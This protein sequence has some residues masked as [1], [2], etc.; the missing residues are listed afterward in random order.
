ME[1]P[2]SVNPDE[3]SNEELCEIL[4]QRKQA[5]RKAGEKYSDAKDWVAAKFGV[6]EIGQNTI[7]I[8]DF[9]VTIDANEKPKGR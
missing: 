2:M 9:K 7:K 8:G 5:S 4:Y 6:P 1:Y 3:L